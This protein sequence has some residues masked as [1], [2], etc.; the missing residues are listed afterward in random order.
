MRIAIVLLLLFAPAGARAEKSAASVLVE[1]AVAAYKQ[2]DFAKAGS[3]FHE[4]YELSHAP[5]QLRNAAKAYQKA[6]DLDSAEASWREFTELDG[7]GASER[8]E[9]E[10]QLALIAEKRRSIAAEEEARRAREEAARV[11]TATVAV[12]APAPVEPRSVLPVGPIVTLAAAV[13]VGIAGGAVYWHSEQRLSRLDDQLEIKDSEGRI[14]GVN[15][16][17][18]EDQIDAINDEHIVAFAL[19]GVAGAAAIA[20]AVW[21]ILGL[22]TAP[23]VSVEGGA[24]RASIAF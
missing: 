19:A 17:D 13:A 1:R 18:A 9:A 14:V 24:V 6:D 15:R 4:A 8:S 2:G 22:D 11:K 16:L 23:A 12:A 7:I 5:E 20:G 21:W 10:A 3:F